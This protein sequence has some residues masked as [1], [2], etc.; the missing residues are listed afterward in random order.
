[1]GKT[2]DPF[3]IDINDD[4]GDWMSALNDLEKEQE[5]SA[6]SEPPPPEA[7]APEKP[8]P[9]PD[10]PLTKYEELC[11]APSMNVAKEDLSVISQFS[12]V[13]ASV[14]DAGR[15][16]DG[17]RKSFPHAVEERHFSTWSE[18]LKMTATTMMREFHALRNGR[19]QKKYDKRCVCEK[20]HSVFMVAL[21]GNICDECR[22]QE[23]PR[24]GGEY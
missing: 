17:L 5:K 9:A 20:C 7:P 3:R 18:N 22:A 12:A 10:R 24:G 23:V 15:S 6:S 21:P 2:P 11:R 19:Q 13:I 1:M 4:A 14:N 8:T 16:I